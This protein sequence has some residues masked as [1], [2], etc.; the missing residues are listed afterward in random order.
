VFKTISYVFHEAPPDA[1]MV[2]GVDPSELL[3]FRD[4]AGQC[5]ASKYTG[6]YCGEATYATHLATQNG[7][8]V[9]TGEPSAHELLSLFQSRG[10][11]I[12]D[13]FGF[14]A[15]RQIPFAKTRPKVNIREVLDSIARQ[16]NRLLGTSVSFTEDDFARWYANHMQNPSELHGSDDQGWQSVYRCRSAQD[17]VSHLV[18]IKR[19][20]SGLEYRGD[21]QNGTVH[22]L[23][24]SH[25]LWR[26]ASDVRM[27]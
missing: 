14:I 25:R 18:C 11:A 2:E 20:G 10:Y 1:V 6:T 7:V 23:P 4:Y 21:C 16:Q 19:R 12:E 22:T 27:E 17:A 3:G 8:E 15:M 9:Y 26:L 13:Y 5:A 24:G